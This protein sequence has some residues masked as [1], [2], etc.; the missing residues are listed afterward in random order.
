MNRPAYIVIDMRDVIKDYSQYRQNYNLYKKFPLQDIIQTVLSTLPY[1]DN[2][3]FFWNEI[4]K[5]FAD[6]LDEMNV[7]LLHF[8]LDMLTEYL[9]QA[10]R[11]KVPDDIDTHAYVFHRWVDTHTLILQNDVNAEVCSSAPK[12]EYFQHTSLFG[13]RALW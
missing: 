3:E 10:I 4:E 2:G 1:E 13:L 11:R 8:F 12:A 9:D 7:D 5:R 6:C